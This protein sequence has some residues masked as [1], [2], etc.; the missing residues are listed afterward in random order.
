MAIAKVRGIRLLTGVWSLRKAAAKEDVE[1]I[2]TL[3]I[4]DR[5]YHEHLID[6]S[7][8]LYCLKELLRYNGRKVRLPEAELRQRIGSLRQSVDD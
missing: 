5:L 3:G 4:L 8:Y 6:S 1:I 7:E 2:G